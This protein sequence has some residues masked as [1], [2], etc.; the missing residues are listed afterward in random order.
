MSVT[1]LVI[2][3][4]IAD[5]SNDHGTTGRTPA[6]LGVDPVG[7]VEIGERLKARRQTVAQ[8]H[9]RGLLPPSRWT[10]S[11][12]PAWNWPDI[13]RWAETTGR[14]SKASDKSKSATTRR[15][16]GKTR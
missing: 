13:K 14:L 5:V 8:W 11:G 15:R 16:G 1:Q 7:M 12:Y 2:F 4:Y 6:A 3:D 10:V 9:Y